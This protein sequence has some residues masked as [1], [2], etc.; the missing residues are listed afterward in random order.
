MTPFLSVY[1][2]IDIMG[3]AQEPPRRAGFT[4]RTERLAP[5]PVVNHFLKRM[6]LEELLEKLSSLP[7]F[8]LSLSDESVE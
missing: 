1:N 5:L 3:R 2:T 4:L 8:V 7:K 6:G